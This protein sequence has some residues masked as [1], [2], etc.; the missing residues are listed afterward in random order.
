MKSAQKTT[1]KTMTSKILLRVVQESFKK[2]VLN[3]LPS[4]RAYIISFIIFFFF[5]KDLI[6]KTLATLIKKKER[7]QIN[8]IRNAREDLTI[9]TME[10]QRTI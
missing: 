8:K 3:A 4:S 10:I 2:Y 5:F 9:G 7:T 6:D 1:Y